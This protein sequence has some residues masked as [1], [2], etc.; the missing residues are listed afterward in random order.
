SEGLFAGLELD[1]PGQDGLTPFAVRS[2]ESFLLLGQAKLT[3]TDRLGLAV[4]V[5]PTSARLF[6]VLVLA[7]LEF[8]SIGLERPARF[9]EDHAVLVDRDLAA[10]QVLLA[11]IERLGPRCQLVFAGPQIGFLL[12]RDIRSLREPCLLGHNAGLSLG[13]VLR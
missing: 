13:E 4:Q 8:S 10:G 11:P 3:F 9:L 6:V 7:L 12:V 5:V 1:L 2:V